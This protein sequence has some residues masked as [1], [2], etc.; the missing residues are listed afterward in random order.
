[1]NDFKIDV[2]DLIKLNIE[3]TEIEFIIDLL[4]KRIFPKQVL[5]EYDELSTP[6]RKSNDRIELALNALVGS[7]YTLLY[8]DRINFTYLYCLAVSVN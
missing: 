3:G 7:G 5:V 4:Q 1:M 2:T 8:K 6:Y